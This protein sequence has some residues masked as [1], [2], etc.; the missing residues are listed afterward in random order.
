MNS[1]DYSHYF[2]RADGLTSCYKVDTKVL[3]VKC[4]IMKINM[5][6]TDRW[7][8]L[9]GAAVLYLLIYTGVVTGSLKVVFG[10]VGVVMIVT[11]MFGVCPLYTLM[12]LSTCPAKK[13]DS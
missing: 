11:A 1:G 4:L 3:T 2:L 13:V 9:F 10:L 8:R 12:G 7:L 5:G 6:N